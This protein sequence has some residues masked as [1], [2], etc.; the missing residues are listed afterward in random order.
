MDKEKVDNR[1]TIE[2]PGWPGETIPVVRGTHDQGVLISIGRALQSAYGI[3]ITHAVLPNFIA[4][5][6][7]FMLPRAAKDE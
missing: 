3:K 4:Y 5:K 1:L 6:W 2:V 7:E